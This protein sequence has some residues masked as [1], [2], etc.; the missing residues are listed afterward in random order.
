MKNLFNKWLANRVHGDEDKELYW[1]DIFYRYEGVIALVIGLLISF[2]INICYSPLVKVFNINMPF[3]EIFK[4]SIIASLFG[5]VLSGGL[6]WLVLFPMYEKNGRGGYS[7]RWDVGQLSF[8]VVTV[9]GYIAMVIF[10]YAII[11]LF[12][13]VKIMS[14]MTGIV[15]ALLSIVLLLLAYPNVVSYTTW[16]FDWAI[17]NYDDIISRHYKYWTSVKD[18]EVEKTNMRV[19]RKYKTFVGV[20]LIVGPTI[21]GFCVASTFTYKDGRP[22]WLNKKTIQSNS[23][24]TSNRMTIE[25]ENE[26][27]VESTADAFHE[28]GEASWSIVPEASDLSQ[29]V[30]QG[31]SGLY[32]GRVSDPDGYTNIRREASINSPITRR[33]NSGEYLYYIP[34]SNGWSKVYSANRSSTFIGYMHTSRIVRVNQNVGADMHRFIESQISVLKSRKLTESDIRN[35]D[36]ATMRLLRNSLFATH[37]YIFKSEDLAEFFSEY[38]WYS[39]LYKDVSS[40]F[41]QTELYNIGF[42]KE[43]E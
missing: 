34:M 19:F 21:L 26:L 27:N 12:Y 14:L 13:A 32:Y 9:L 40:T 17:N 23:A 10:L 2:V 28:M 36:S 38:P 4:L 43:H 25:N 1:W 15:Y 24:P 11:R 16:R 31:N 3:V 20:I 7:K 33:Y 18:I 39:P 22:L 8:V 6:A 30:Q 29:D 5:T 42:L 41:N 35:Y 37:N